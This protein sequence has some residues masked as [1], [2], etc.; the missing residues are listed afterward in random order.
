[1]DN[2]NILTVAFGT[3]GC[4]LNQY[5]TDALVGDFSRAGYQI[6][7]FQETANVYIINTC[8]VT[9]KSDQKT[10]NMINRARKKAGN[11][12]III[13]GCFVE[14]DNGYLK[15]LEENVYSVSNKLKYKVFQFVE[16][17]LHGNAVDLT[18]FE[19]NVFDFHPSEKS[20]HTRSMIKIQDGCDNFCSFCIVPYVRGRAISRPLPDVLRDIKK[21]IALGYKEIVLTGVNLARY[22]YEGTGFSGLLNA[23]L[24]L[25]GD[26]R[27]RVSSLE[28]EKFT[29]E[30]FDLFGH[31]KFCRHLHLCLQ[32]GSENILRKMNRNYGIKLY[33]ETIHQVKKRFPD[34]NFTTDIIVGFPG[35]TEENFE[36]SCR[37]ARNL[38][39]S[40]IHTFQYSP[41]QGTKAVDFPNQIPPQIKQKRSEVIRDI[42]IRNKRIYRESLLGKKQRVLVEKLLPDGMAKGYGELYI[43]IVFN[44]P[45]A[46]ENEFYDVLITAIGEGNDPPLFAD[47]Q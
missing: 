26:F 10:R 1:M 16:E 8:T 36:D 30:L 32:S 9:N 44:Y 12:L 22:S 24:E 46:K 34:F 19:K 28:P 13:T 25:P 27:V 20:L 3:L 37:A 40:H 45:E 5:E 47:I 23:V 35:E 17:T 2:R 14:N 41:R 31:P 43:P 29:A 11:P 21:T 33:T 6:V 4:K 7:Q 38:E 42:S 39:F 18:T 15:E